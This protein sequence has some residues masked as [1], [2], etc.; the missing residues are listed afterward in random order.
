MPTYEMPM[1]LRLMTKPEMRTILK[2]TAQLIFDKGGFIRKIENLGVKPTPFKISAHGAIHKEANYF[3]FYFDVPPTKVIEIQDEY[4][5]DIDIA[6][7][8]IVKELKPLQQPCTLHE[9]LLPPP[10]RPSV[11]KLLRV[12][13]IQEKKNMNKQKFQYNNGLDYLPFQR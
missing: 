5:R 9:E 6:R 12:A 8:A 10:Y 2:R 1:L 7:L 11:K 13:Q 3:I 4:T